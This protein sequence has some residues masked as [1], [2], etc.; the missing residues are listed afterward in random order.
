MFVIAIIW[1]GFLIVLLNNYLQKMSLTLN[2]FIHKYP[3]VASIID[4]FK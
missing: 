3:L 2:Q 1:G 4:I